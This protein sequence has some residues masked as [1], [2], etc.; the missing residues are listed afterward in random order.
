MNLGLEKFMI[1]Y[2]NGICMYV[3]YIADQKKKMMMN[4]ILKKMM[5]DVRANIGQNVLGLGLPGYN[6]VAAHI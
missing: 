2:I 4:E 5:E 3:Y 6:N 1:E